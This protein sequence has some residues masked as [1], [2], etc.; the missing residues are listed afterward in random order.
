[1]KP[2][3]SDVRFPCEAEVL[4]DHP[5]PLSTHLVTLASRTF[6]GRCDF[7]KNHLLGKL[8]QHDRSP[9]SR[10]TMSNDSIP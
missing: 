4:L 6:D 8:E 7:A 5:I 1:M 2:M 10:R 9:R 3:P